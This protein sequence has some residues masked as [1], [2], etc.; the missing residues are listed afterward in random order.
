[1]MRSGLWLLLLA[2]LAGCSG[3]P[4][5]P[6]AA[7]HAVVAT[8]QGWW[9]AA[10]QFQWPKSEKWPAWHRDIQVAYRIIEP[11][12]E[13]HR[14]EITLWRVH[15]RAG[16]DRRGHRF[17]FI[18]YASPVAA[19]QIYADIEANPHLVAW[20]Q[21]GWIQKVHF[22]DVTRVS[23]P[24]IEDT[25]D[26]GWPL[27]IQQTW[28]AFIMGVSEMWLDLVTRL[29]DEY[30]SDEDEEASYLKVNQALDQLWRGNAR[31]AFLHH[32]NAI[33]AYQPFLTRY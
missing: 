15:R 29:G 28:P 9:Y 19:S 7:P 3:V 20:R 22:D 30:V 31:H 4:T 12:L 33:Y 11:V 23:R 26:P 2:V 1:M 18:F 6:K 8:G 21:A 16:R 14:E 32:L 5:K 13:A 24:H 27:I 25:S 17:S 10:F